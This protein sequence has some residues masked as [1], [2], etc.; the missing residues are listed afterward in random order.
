VW[1]ENRG[2]P[3]VTDFPGSRLVFFSNRCLNFNR[4]FKTLCGI[5]GMTKRKR[6]LTAGLLAVGLIGFVMASQWG[7]AAEPPAYPVATTPEMMQLLRDEHDLV[8]EM[9]RGQLAAERD[10]YKEPRM[11][12]STASVP[13][14]GDRAT[15]SVRP[16]RN[17]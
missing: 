15:S 17:I 13:R 14:P 6:L 3:K 12:I 10:R 11:P 7:Y 9:I 1:R 2:T 8:A 4:P 16:R 5:R